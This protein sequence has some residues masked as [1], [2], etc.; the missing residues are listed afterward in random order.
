VG[1]VKE[2]ALTSGEA[3]GTVGE[4][5]VCSKPPFGLPLDSGCVTAVAC[6]YVGPPE[7]CSAVLTAACPICWMGPSRDGLG[8]DL[9]W[10]WPMCLGAAALTF[11]GSGDGEANDLMGERSIAGVAGELSVLSANGM[12]TSLRDSFRG[13][14]VAETS[15]SIPSMPVIS[16]EQLEM[17][18]WYCPYSPIQSHLES[19]FNLLWLTHLIFNE[20]SILHSR[21]FSLLEAAPQTG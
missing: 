13:G 21:R 2:R 16:D 8:E 17:C 12:S 6:K 19:A 5:T 4:S 20:E 7:V 9:P 10:T 18:F 1:P 14:V 11:V 15:P 3:S